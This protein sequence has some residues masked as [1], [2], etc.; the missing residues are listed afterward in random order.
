MHDCCLIY[1]S[2]RWKQKLW[3]VICVT[4][5]VLWMTASWMQAIMLSYPRQNQRKSVKQI[6][7]VSICSC[8]WPSESN[9]QVVLI[10]ES[11][12]IKESQFLISDINWGPG[13]PEQKM[14]TLCDA[15]QRSKRQHK[16]VYMVHTR[17]LT[18]LWSKPPSSDHVKP[19]HKS[20]HSENSYYM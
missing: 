9:L 11:L 3:Q 7:D 8:F 18:E 12:G 4:F 20:K 13:V 14:R 16:N 17:G 19:T 1:V 2:V 5:P 10:V 15:N 6:A